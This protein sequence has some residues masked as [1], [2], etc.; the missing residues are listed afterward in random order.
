MGTW[1]CY[2]KGTVANPP[3]QR[4]RMEPMGRNDV[5]KTFGW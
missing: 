5:F 1:R 2:A 3:I 4:L